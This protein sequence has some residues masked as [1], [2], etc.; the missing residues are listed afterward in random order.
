MTRLF[1]FYAEQD[2]ERWGSSYWRTL[3]GRRVR[4]T[5]CSRFEDGRDC[6][7]EGRVSL[8]EVDPRSYE[9]DPEHVG[10]EN[11]II[12]GSNEKD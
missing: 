6:V 9:L 12:R 2:V 7:R 4:A 11:E 10:S 3:D 1:A 8:G 5:L